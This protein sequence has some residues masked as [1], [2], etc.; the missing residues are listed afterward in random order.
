[1]QGCVL[2]VLGDDLTFQLRFPTALAERAPSNSPLIAE[3]T[4][5]RLLTA[6]GHLD[7]WSV[8]ATPRARP[9]HTSQGVFMMTTVSARSRRRASVS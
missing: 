9:R 4:P 7:A 1:M 8:H 5:S 2:S 6:F 3:P